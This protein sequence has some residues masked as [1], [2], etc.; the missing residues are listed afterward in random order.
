MIGS[1]GARETGQHDAALFVLR[2]PLPIGPLVA[3]QAP[4]Q[5]A[6]CWAGRDCSSEDRMTVRHD[7]VEVVE[8][9]DGV[10]LSNLRSTAVHVPTRSSTARSLLITRRG[11]GAVLG[12]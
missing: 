1:L 4:A 12:A 10:S 9:R 3:Q 11:G 2:E 5:Q 6:S 8:F 7:G